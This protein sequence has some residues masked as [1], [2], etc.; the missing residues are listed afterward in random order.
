MK[1]GYARVSS[2]EQQNNSSLDTQKRVLLDLG[3]ESK[4]IYKDVASAKNLE[5]EGLQNL[6]KVVKRGDHIYVHRLDR[7]ARNTVETLKL[8][9]LWDQEGISFS[10]PGMQLS[11]NSAISKMLRTLYSLFAELETNQREERVKEGIARAKKEGLYTGRKTVI[12]SQV[13]EK[14]RKMVEKNN[15]KA[16]IAAA[17]K[18]SRTTVYKVIQQLK[19]EKVR[20]SGRS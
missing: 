10:I 6:M 14:V 5:R 4:H 15:S 3:V 1:Y 11:G 2:V 13:V 16:D 9:E 8:I 20:L 7:L 12:T 18:V 17:T 19:N